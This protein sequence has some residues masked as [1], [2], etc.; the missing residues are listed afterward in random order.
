MSYKCEGC[1]KTSRIAPHEPGCTVAA[2]Y[3]Q[4]RAMKTHDDR[5][6]NCEHASESHNAGTGKCYACPAE[7][8]CMEFVS[9]P[10][11]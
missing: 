3:E 5:C 9:K 1:G 7:A 4:Q 6:A 2:Y 10:K 11:D 8:R